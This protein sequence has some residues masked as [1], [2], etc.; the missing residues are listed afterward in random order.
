MRSTG[1]GLE[2]AGVRGHGRALP[3]PQEKNDFKCCGGE[4]G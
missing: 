3:L 4:W 2:E 1:P